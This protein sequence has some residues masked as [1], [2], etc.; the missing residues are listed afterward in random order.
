LKLGHARAMNLSMR[1]SSLVCAVLGAMALLAAGC[2]EDDRPATFSYIHAAILTPQCTTSACHTK[3]TAYAG[4]ELHSKN[5]AYVILTGRVCGADPVD[6][7][8]QRNF[9]TPGQPEN[10]RLMHLLRGE[11]VRRPM[12]PDRPL[13]DIDI[14]LIEEW[15]LLGAE[16]D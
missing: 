7:E 12:P 13:P 11:E 16:C 9:V 6:G 2:G 14:A 5:A 8:A 4:V 1:G 10:S 3:L 15:I